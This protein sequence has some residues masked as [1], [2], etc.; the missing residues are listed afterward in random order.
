MDIF[1][2]KR[3]FKETEK[4][5]YF[6]ILFL[7]LAIFFAGC[8]WV[9]TPPIIPDNGGM[10]EYDSQFISLLDKLKTPSEL[11]VFLSTCHYKEHN[12]GGVR[13]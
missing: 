12:I 2:F 8:S 4:K 5:Y 13:S 6:V 11:L 3:V 10:D 9:T 7:V 1:G